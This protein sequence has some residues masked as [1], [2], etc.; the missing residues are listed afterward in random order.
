[1]AI[2]WGIICG[3]L[4]LLPGWGVGLSALLSLIVPGSGLY[5][6]VVGL[7]IN[8]I[9]EARV[10]NSSSGNIYAGVVGDVGNGGVELGNQL[11]IW[12]T[13]VWIVGVVVGLLLPPIL[14]GGG[15]FVTALIL[16][17]MLGSLGDKW[18]TGVVWVCAVTVLMS[19][20]QVA[21]IGD[22][23][24]VI[25]LSLFVIP[26]IAVSHSSNIP[27]GNAFPNILTL[28]WGTLVAV[29]APGVSPQSIVSV[30]DGRAGRMTA[31]ITTA[32]VEV[33]VE[34]IGLAQIYKGGTLGK[35]LI[36]S[37]VIAPNVWVL[38]STCAL[39][40][41]VGFI[42]LQ[43]NNSLGSSVGLYSESSAKF[44]GTVVGVIGLVIFT[45]PWA[46]LF[47]P[48][49]FAITTFIGSLLPDP[50]IRGLTF[51]SLLV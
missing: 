48:L 30:I 19:V 39:A 41:C 32:V 18:W 29:A 25:G 15:I 43:L 34:G 37:Y 22:P 14:G 3:M 40:L 12:K 16:V 8:S 11:I 4:C 47:I 23:V 26:N 20:C 31:Y 9:V 2:V 13:I 21:G 50:S 38:V 44:I 45:G 1:M 33:L 35:A 5:A 51:I 7:I 49:G 42:G 36:S 6:I 17:I 28:I 46:L 24:T 27:L 10:G